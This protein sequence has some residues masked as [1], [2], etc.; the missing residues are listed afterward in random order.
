MALLASLA[1]L[2]LTACSQEEIVHGLEESQANQVLVALDEDGMRAEKRREEGSEATWRVEVASSEAPRAQRLLAERE[3]PR[4]RPPGFGE[5]F[6]KGSIVP[7]P[8]EERALYLHALSGELARSVEAIDGVVE[9]RVHL[10]LP[11]ADSLRPEPVTTPRAAV[12]VKVR[13]GARSRLEPLAPGIQSL[14]AG[15]VAGLDA[16]AV[17]VVV[18]EAAPAARTPDGGAPAR[19]RSVLLT[20][21]GV[22]ASLA[23]ALPSLALASS[24]LDLRRFLGRFVRRAP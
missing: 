22:A 10:A 18:A 20:L 2:A 24:H 12:L 5:I 6:G 3:L 23:L 8:A 15:A 7:T 19:R 4:P 16:T 11:P 1:L 13:P 17:S 14:V 9:A 21:A